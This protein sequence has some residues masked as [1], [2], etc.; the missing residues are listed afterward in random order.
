MSRMGTMPKVNNNIG[1]KIVTN[2]PFYNSNHATLK[3]RKKRLSALITNDAVCE[4]FHV[5]LV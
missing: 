5:F 1:A 3:K 4:A 2:V